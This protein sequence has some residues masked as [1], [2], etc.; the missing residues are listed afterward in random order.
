M[1]KMILFW[2]LVSCVL[3]IRHGVTGAEEQMIDRVVAVVGDEI[4][5]L[6]DVQHNLNVQMMNRNLSMNSS[7]QVL[8]QLQH[9]VLRDMINQKLLLEKA[10]RDSIVADPRDIDLFM[11][12][13]LANLKQQLGTEEAYQE[14]LRENGFTEQQLR[15]MFRI[16][17]EKNVLEQMLLQDIKRRISVTPQEMETWYNAHKDSLPTIPEQ[18]KLSHIMLTPKVTPEKEQIVR[19]KL[20]DIRDRARAGEDFGQLAKQYSEDPVTSPNGGDIG[21][22][23]R[24]VMIQEFSDVAFTLKPGMISDVVKTIYGLHIVKVDTTRMVVDDRGQQSEEVKARHILLRLEPGEEDEKATIAKLNEI[25]SE[26]LSGASTFENM[27]KQYSDDKDSRDL[28]GKLNWQTRES[29]QNIDLAQFYT[30]AKK[31]KPGEI[32]EPFRT[33]YGYHIIELDE[34]KPEHVVTIKEDRTLI[35]NQLNQE[36]TMQEL[37]RIL[38]GLNDETYIDIRLE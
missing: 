15:Y 26:V 12:E 37:D 14:A 35:E 13:H 33:K 23:G 10:S 36:K 21:F 17:A 2:L 28:G 19:K 29:L 6:S 27:A 1:K 34:Y 9:E 5:L 32:S 7:P 38:S 16:M 31:L 30:E 11:N 22:F 25:R 3:C 8:R 24:G 20:E 18:F 4:I